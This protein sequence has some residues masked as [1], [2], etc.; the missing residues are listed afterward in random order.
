MI[1]T[2][3]AGFGLWMARETP[4]EDKPPG[5]YPTGEIAYSE[6]GRA[7]SAAVAKSMK[8]RS[9]GSICRRLG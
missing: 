5:G 6:G 8:A 1:E 7:R 9:A 3:A 2:Q 4:W